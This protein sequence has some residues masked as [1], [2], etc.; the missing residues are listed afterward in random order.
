[1]NG[2]AT[3]AGQRGADP[4]RDIVKAVGGGPE[5]AEVIL[6][7]YACD[8]DVERL[9]RERPD[10]SGAVIDRVIAFYRPLRVLV[11]AMLTVRL[12]T[13]QDPAKRGEVLQEWLTLAGLE[14]PAFGDAP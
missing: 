13:H 6:A 9:R 5:A 12:A 4:L 8:G 7:W 11:E 1:M 14:D 3:G 2:S 10:M